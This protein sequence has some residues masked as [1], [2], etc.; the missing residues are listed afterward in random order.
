MENVEIQTEAQLMITDPRYKECL[1]E[2]SNILATILSF[3]PSAKPLF[4]LNKRYF[5]FVRQV[6]IS[7]EVCV[8]C[9]DA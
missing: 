7:K 5:A 3:V 8:T 9:E 1:L 2:N 4:V 6:V